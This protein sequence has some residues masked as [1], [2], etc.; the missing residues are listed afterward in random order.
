MQHRTIAAK[1]VEAVVE[2]DVVEGVE[3]GGSAR[4]TLQLRASGELTGGGGIR[5]RAP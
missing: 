5:L 1:L 3:H 2:F 4:F